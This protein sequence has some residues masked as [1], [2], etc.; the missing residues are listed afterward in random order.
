MQA[1]DQRAGGEIGVFEP[2]LGLMQLHCRVLQQYRRRHPA[3]LQ[4]QVQFRLLV[5]DFTILQEGTQPLERLD[6]DPM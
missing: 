3:T 1:L 4:A 2:C 5:M 6:H